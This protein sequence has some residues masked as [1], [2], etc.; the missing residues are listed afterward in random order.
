MDF[1][2]FYISNYNTVHITDLADSN[3]ECQEK[4]NKM[5]KTGVAKKNSVI[6][7]SKSTFCRCRN[8]KAS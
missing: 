2:S 5:E 3:D 6:H 1:R 7:I 4:Q 8:E